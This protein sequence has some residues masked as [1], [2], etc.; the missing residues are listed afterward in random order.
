MLKKSY[1]AMSILDCQKI[2]EFIKDQASQNHWNITC[3]GNSKHKATK[4]NTR[5]HGYHET[6]WTEYVE[7]Y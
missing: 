2:E 3:T 6:C 5:C 7:Q 4:C 1:I